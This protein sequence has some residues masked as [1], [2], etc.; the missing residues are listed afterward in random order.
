MGRETHLGTLRETHLPCLGCGKDPFCCPRCSLSPRRPISPAGAAGT[1]LD[2]QEAPQ[3]G[4]GCWVVLFL[5]ALSLKLSAAE[6]E[7]NRPLRYG[8][9]KRLKFSRATRLPTLHPCLSNQAPEH[10]LCRYLAA[11]LNALPFKAN[12]DNRCQICQR[13]LQLWIWKPNSVFLETT[14]TGIN[15]QNC[16]EYCTNCDWKQGKCFV[17]L[18]QKG[19]NVTISI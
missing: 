15:V 8:E 11:R 10:C 16:W 7:K 4:K 19:W 3:R 18:V 6:R 12:Y 13:P 1:G 5:E 17:W 2:R 14:G 9:P